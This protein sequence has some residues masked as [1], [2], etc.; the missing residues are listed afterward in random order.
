MSKDIEDFCHSCSTSA[1]YG[2]Q[3]AAKP[4]LSHPTPT[5]PGQFVSQDIFAFGHKQLITVNHYS[6]FYELDEPVDTLSATIINLIKAHLAHHGIP[7]RCLTDNGLQFVSHEYKKFAQT[8]DFE[9][10]TSSPY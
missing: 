8:F 9:H 5:L 4:M 1:Q 2:K 7:L 10:V 3:A 6:D